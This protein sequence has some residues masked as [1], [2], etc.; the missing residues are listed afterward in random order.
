MYADLFFHA[1]PAFMCTQ[2]CSC[3]L[4]PYSSNGSTS[5]EMAKTPQTF[6]YMTSL[7][8]GG[9]QISLEDELGVRLDA[10]LLGRRYATETIR[11]TD[12][13]ANFMHRP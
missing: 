6:H 10:D 2:A 1:Q 12:L 5:Q 11:Y 7:W 13:E 9:V 8:F 3:A 4:T